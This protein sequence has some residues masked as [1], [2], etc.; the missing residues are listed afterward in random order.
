MK[1]RILHCFNQAA[2]TYDAFADVQ[3]NVAQR[4]AERLSAVQANTILEIGCGTGLLTHQL[5]PAFPHANWQLT[6]IA[7]AMVAAC[8]QRF[9]AMPTMKIACMDGEAL[10]VETQFDLIVSSMAMHWF[11][12]PEKSFAEIKNKLAP[13]G[14]F[15]FAMLGQQSLVEWRSICQQENLPSPTPIFP[16]YVPLQTA[17]PDFK[18]TTEI[19]PVRYPTLHAFLTRLKN[20]GA[21]ATHTHYQSL[22]AGKLRAIL[23]KYHREMTI[24]YEVIYGNYQRHD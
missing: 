5:L 7:P 4:L 14:L 12:Q 13:K 22:P 21:T 2:D 8:Q 24:S 19:I 6:D 23:R 15:A 3:A 18:L 11:T 9:A 20:I 1:E 10:T 17:F 16:D